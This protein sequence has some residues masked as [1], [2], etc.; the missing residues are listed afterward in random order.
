MGIYFKQKILV[1][2][3]IGII[4]F[5]LS[6][7]LFFP[8]FSDTN[9]NCSY[10]DSW[11]VN[12]TQICINQFI[13]ISNLTITEFGNL[14]LINSILIASFATSI[15][16][17]ILGFCGIFDNVTILNKGYLTL[18]NST[19]ILNN[20][21]GEIAM[22]SLGPFFSYDSNIEMTT[23]GYIDFLNKTILLNSNLP[24]WFQNVRF[25]NSE[26][27]IKNSYIGSAGFYH[28]TSAVIEN[29]S[30]LWLI[31][32]PIYNL[33][34]RVVN[35]SINNFDIGFWGNLS[36]EIKNL[37]PGRNISF[38]TGKEIVISSDSTIEVIN[39][40]INFFSL[41]NMVSENVSFKI[42]N[43]SI[44]YLTLRPKSLNEFYNSSFYRIWI[45]SWS[46]ATLPN[47][48]LV[49]VYPG[50]N[51]YLNESNIWADTYF[52]VRLF[53]CNVSEWL[54]NIYDTQNVTLINSSVGWLGI[55]K[56]LFLP[57]KQAT[58]T[59]MNSKIESISIEA[60]VTIIN[61]TV[62][63]SDIINSQVQN[64]IVQNSIIINSTVDPSEVYDSLILNSQI[65]DS[66]LI[67]VTIK[68]A[69]VSNSKIENKN[70]PEVTIIP[71]IAYKHENLSCEI[72]SFQER[73][74][75][76]SISYDW[77]NG[78]DWIGLNSS[79]LPYNYT[80]SFQK[81]ICKVVIVGNNVNITIFSNNTVEILPIYGD[82]KSMN[83]NINISIEINFSDS[84]EIGRV[85][86]ID[87]KE[88][89]P[90]VE[91]NFNFSQNV[92]NITKI[93]ILV[94]NE[95]YNKSWIIINGVE[96]SQNFTKTVYLKKKLKSNYICVK[97][98]EI[99][100]ISEV[101]ENCNGNYE[102]LVKCDNKTYANYTC[103]DLGNYYKITGLKNSAITEV[104]FEQKAS[105]PQQNL[106][107]SSGFEFSGA[108]MPI[109]IKVAK[110]EPKWSCTEW[111]ECYPNGSQYRICIDL[112]SCN[113]TE[114]KLEEIKKC[115]YIPNN[116]TN[117]TN[118]TVPICGNNICEIGENQTNCCI[119][120]GCPEG[121]ECKDNKCVE[122]K[123]EI[124][125]P[126][127]GWF[128]QVI[129]NPLVIV[130]IVAMCIAGIISVFLKFYKLK[131]KKN[132]K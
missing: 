128:I 25:S 83:S 127:T 40:N 92:L 62:Q 15:E 131:S 114:G 21:I 116:V 87:E 56:D 28:N 104:E 47:L 38:S 93:R 18:I 31:T 111:S 89:H 79:I 74:E 16:V 107:S 82:V 30:F 49:N 60:N 120:C 96:L 80:K 105:S 76:L 86:F 123:K 34:I 124:Q 5:I 37:H 11:I 2:L 106:S 59:L 63:N 61:S 102:F 118:V 84:K 66:K 50:N 130:I 41:G 33:F 53:N 68:N 97:D 17:C 26:V 110:C 57:E 81:W 95:S 69:V 55:F 1:I 46:A 115:T 39:S 54:I 3:V 99:E 109:T 32:T 23:W 19:I 75:N 129:S 94:S 98:A 64:S 27:Y 113:T 24:Y 71:S 121:L 58:L 14:T 36:I 132:K 88:K 20:S 43:S 13:N 72:F 35:S 8:V 22:I 12:D 100:D 51:L 67:N 77:F 9:N 70:L 7:V 90:I 44:Q 91:F 29:S 45:E 112:N 6:L 65:I 122:I 42:F 125:T 103:E 73:N 117:I 126:I 108:P 119:D 85:R 101:S 78:T 4:P 10:N 48:H 52:I